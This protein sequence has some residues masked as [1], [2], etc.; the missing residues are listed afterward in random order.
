[1]KGISALK[2]SQLIDA[3][4]AL[5][6]KEEQ[7]RAVRAAEHGKTFTKEAGSSS[8]Q[9][10]RKERAGSQAGAAE[11]G[12]SIRQEGQAEHSRRKAE[13]QEKEAGGSHLNGEKRSLCAEPA[14]PGE[15]SY[16][17]PS[18]G[19]RGQRLRQQAGEVPM[20]P[21]QTSRG[22]RYHAGVSGRK[23][24]GSGAQRECTARPGG[25]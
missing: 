7:E 20:P 4:L 18:A 6:E 8:G 21:I 11:K 3:M 16:P 23:E 15:Y 9:G 14:A 25:A 19:S 13:R 17:V 24:I 10:R 1:M 22:R 5:D 2:K 12:E